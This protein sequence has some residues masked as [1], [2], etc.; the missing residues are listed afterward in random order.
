MGLRLRLTGARIRRGRL[1]RTTTSTA[2]RGEAGRCRLIHTSVTVNH[3]VVAL[4]IRL[5]VCPFVLEFPHDTVTHV[6]VALAAR[7]ESYAGTA[8]CTIPA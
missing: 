8:Q 2:G 7:C 5:F 1:S 4:P 3:G 6:R